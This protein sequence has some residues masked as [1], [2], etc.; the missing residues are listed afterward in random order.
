M[1]GSAANAAV[2]AA[3]AARI[4]AK[5]TFMGG[6]P[7]ARV[8]RASFGGKGERPSPDRIFTKV[9][10]LFAAVVVGLTLAASAAAGT[11]QPRVLAIQYGPDL[12]VNPVTEDWVINK[13]HR[14]EN[15]HYDAAVILLDTPGGLSTSM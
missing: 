14:A 3:S 6:V 12:E 9:R 13:I 11:A 8:A 10:A 1:V 15:D 7:G 4:V 5:R 2:G